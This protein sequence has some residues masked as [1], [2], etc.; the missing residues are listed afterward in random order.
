MTIYID[1]LIILN[2]IID[3]IVLLCVDVLLKRRVKV[4]RLLLSA[5]IGSL[6]FLFLLIIKNNFVINIYKFITSIIMIL[7]AFKYNSFNYFKEN[8]FW[9]YIIS[10]ILGGGMYLIYDGVSLSNNSLV[11]IKNK[12]Q[13]SFLIILLIGVCIL[14]KFIDN[15]SKLKDIN[16]NYYDVDIYYDD[17]KLT[18]M[19]F[20]DSGN[21]LFDPYFGYPIILV[22]EELIN[23]R[24]KCFYTPFDSL[25]NHGLMRCFKPKY[26]N[27]NGV[28]KRK[29]IIGLSDINYNG[30]KIILNKEIL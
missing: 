9:L 16:S 7:I 13:F 15:S 29:V 23:K 3:F 21:N 11:F 8:I 24:L 28:K 25:N 19:A 17:V 22:N 14:K 18:G 10:I 20:L 2:F 27:I 26:I 1:L 5:L 6:S 30:I 12:Y 4:Y